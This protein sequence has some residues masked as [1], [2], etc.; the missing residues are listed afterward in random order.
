[1]VMKYDSSRDYPKTLE[2]WLGLAKAWRR[3]LTEIVSRYTWRGNRV[4]VSVKD[5]IAALDADNHEEI[6]NI[7][8]CAWDLAP[9]S[10]TIH[11]NI[12][13]EVLCDLCS[14]YSCCLEEYEYRNG[15]VVDDAENAENGE[16]DYDE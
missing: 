8:I 2:Q 6:Y 4:N 9:D 13:W 14:E 12:G 5:F 7:L 3:S 11:E 10:P 15:R 16:D 1:M